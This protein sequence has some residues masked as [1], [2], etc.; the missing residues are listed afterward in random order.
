MNKNTLLFTFLIS[1]VFL[2]GSFAFV[3]GEDFSEAEK[4]I[5]SKIGCENITDNQLE[6][7]GDYYMEQMHPGE[8]HK[9][10]ETR[11]GGEGSES[12]RVTHINMG[13]IFYCGQSGTM[14]PSMMNV[15][16]GRSGYNGNGMMGNYNYYGTNNYSNF[17]YN[18]LLIVLLIVVI[19]TLIVVIVLLSIRNTRGGKKA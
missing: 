12:L 4:L 19:V 10:M 9:I 7:L 5:A 16:M 15:M 1:A 6:M 13:K 18:L 3:I 2:A 11:M 8:Y 17:N 14:Y